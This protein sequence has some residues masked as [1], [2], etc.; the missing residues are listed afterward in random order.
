MLLSRLVGSAGGG[1]PRW[2]VHGVGELVEGDVQVVGTGA[3]VRQSQP[4]AAAGRTSGACAHG[5]SKLGVEVDAVLGLENLGTFG[6]EA[7]MPLR[8]IPPPDM[9]PV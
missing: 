8:Q 5:S 1:H 6:P 7:G 9:A 4:I 3:A 2:V